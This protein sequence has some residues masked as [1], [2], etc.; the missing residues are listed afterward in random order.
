MFW[1]PL[2]RTAGWGQETLSYLHLLARHVGLEP[3]DAKQECVE[4]VTVPFPLQPITRGVEDD[5]SN[6]RPY[7]QKGL[8]ERNKSSLNLLNASGIRLKAYLTDIS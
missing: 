4:G 1:N 8:N 2:G 7:L 6:E 3:A 5:Y